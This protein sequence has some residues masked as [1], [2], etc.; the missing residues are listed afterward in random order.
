MSA[1]IL[2]L[3]VFNS[4]DPADCL[5]KI[6]DQIEAGAL[7]EVS[8]V[9]VVVFGDELHIYGAGDESGGSDVSMLFQAAN[10]HMVRCVADYKE[11]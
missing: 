9:G 7:G 4:R 11:E 2:K 8:T 1:K 3:P 10:L 5:R 6:A